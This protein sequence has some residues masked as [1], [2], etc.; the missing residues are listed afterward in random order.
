MHSWPT[1]SSSVSV[2][3]DGLKSGDVT[4]YSTWNLLKEAQFELLT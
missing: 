2:L 3:Q 4:S 1:L